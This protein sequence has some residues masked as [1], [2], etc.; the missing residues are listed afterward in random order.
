MSYK[1]VFTNL[2]QPDVL[3]LEHSKIY[4]LLEISENAINN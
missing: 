2:T 4:S 3:D 1:K